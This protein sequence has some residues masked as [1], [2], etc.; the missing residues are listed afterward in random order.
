MTVTHQ[1]AAP[2][3]TGKAPPEALTSSPAVRVLIVDDD[4]ALRTILSVMLTQS[5]FVCRTAASGEEALRLLE[6][7]PTDVVISDL[8]MPGI[9]GMD[10]LI[11]VR[12]RHPHLAFL[13]RSEEH[14]SEL[15]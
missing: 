5:A 11:E 3:K 1:T 13:M 7:Q 6:N 12:E 15:Q 4:K 8:R 2:E 14:T 10:L 9:S